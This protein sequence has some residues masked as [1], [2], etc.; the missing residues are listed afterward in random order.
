METEALGNSEMAYS[1]IKR[2]HI[3]FV[4]L[5]PLAASRSV[6]SLSSRPVFVTDLQDD[7]TFPGEHCNTR[8][9]SP[10]GHGKECERSCDPTDIEKRKIYV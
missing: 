3:Q 9:L 2:T 10:R 5:P 6:L 1:Y 7:P 8:A 4:F